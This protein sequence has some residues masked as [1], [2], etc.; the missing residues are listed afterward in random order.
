VPAQSPHCACTEWYHRPVSMLAGRTLRASIANGKFF[1]CLAAVSIVTHLF[2]ISIANAQAMD[3]NKNCATLS[4]PGK[5]PDYE[6]LPKYR[7]ER[8][9]PDSP[10]GGGLLLG[11][12]VSPEAIN[13]GR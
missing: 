1:L 11:I 8:R 12:S 2:T 10:P 3:L 9:E 5:Y 4:A 7:I 6:P 13:G